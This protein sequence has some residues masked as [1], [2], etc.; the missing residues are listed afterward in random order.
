M[1][2]LED[3][4]PPDVKDPATY[5]PAVQAYID[6]VLRELPPEAPGPDPD[7]LF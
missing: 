7:P 2:E 3:L 5:W 1:D 6:A 4:G